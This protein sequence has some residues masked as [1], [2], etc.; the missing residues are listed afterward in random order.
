M[1][2]FSWVI[3][4]GFFLG[5]YLALKA[6][7][8]SLVN[9]AEIYKDFEAEKKKGEALNDAIRQD[10]IVNN[11]TDINRMREKLDAALRRKRDS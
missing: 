6:W 9:A 10:A 2:T 1:T 4:G 3:I 7:A 11:N 5:A 8:N